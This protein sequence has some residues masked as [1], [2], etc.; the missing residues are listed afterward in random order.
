MSRPYK[1]YSDEVDS[2]SYA[3]RFGITWMDWGLSLLDIV[4]LEIG[5]QESIGIDH[6]AD[7]DPPDRFP[8]QRRDEA[9]LAQPRLRVLP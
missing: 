6:P 2:W 1:G 8:V 5:A 9:R 3:K 7:E 4:S